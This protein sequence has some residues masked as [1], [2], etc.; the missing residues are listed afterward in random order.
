MDPDKTDEI[1]I[2]E[3]RKQASATARHKAIRQEVGWVLDKGKIRDS[4]EDSLAAVTLSE[5]SNFDSLSVG[6][7]AIA[8][9]MGGH[10]AGE[11]ASK[12]AMRSAVHKII[13]DLSE[14]NDGL[15]ENIQNWLRGAVTLA[16]QSVRNKALDRDR[17]MGTTLVV[18]V[19]FGHNLHVV[20]VGDSRAYVISPQTV[21]QITRD[22]SFVQALVDT[23][24]ITPEEA[25]GHPR[26]NIL[27]QS[28]GSHDELTI[29]HFNE[30]LK[31]DE[32]LLLCSDGLWGTMSNDQ[33]GRLVREANSPA[34]AAQTLVNTAN[35]AGGQDNISAIVV[36]LQPSPKSSNE[37]FDLDKDD[38]LSFQRPIIP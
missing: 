33:I 4:N 6:I 18:A 31:E 32:W 23:G 11:V 9:G 37:E 36:R 15:P 25:I 12:L 26:R 34:E 22:H 35:E 24:A 3:I 1:R 16:N 30:T 19:V 38:T 8:D 29:D 7:Y 2:D 20:N 5:A 21:R 10:D 13:Q 28:V 17:N 27:T 14:A